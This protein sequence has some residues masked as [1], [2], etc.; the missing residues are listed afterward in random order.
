MTILAGTSSP[1][2]AVQVNNYVNTK[3]IVTVHII[4]LSERNIKR[5]KNA[6]VNNISLH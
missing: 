5:P 1:L 3:I 2:G 6:Y 4:A